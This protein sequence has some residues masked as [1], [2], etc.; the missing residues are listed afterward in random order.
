MALRHMV[1]ILDLKR[2]FIDCVVFLF[3]CS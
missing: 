2:T 3:T 1:C